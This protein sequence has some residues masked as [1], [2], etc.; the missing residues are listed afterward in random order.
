MYVGVLLGVW[1]TPR[2]T[3]GHLILAVGFTAYVMLA[4]RYEERDL[5][6]QFGAR[7]QRWRYSS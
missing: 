7:Y 1:T 6:H 4:M 5:A 3:A 2:M